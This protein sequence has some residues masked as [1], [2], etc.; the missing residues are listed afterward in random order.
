VVFQWP[1]GTLAG[2]LMPRG[3]QPRSGVMLVLV[4]VSWSALEEKRNRELK[5]VRKLLKAA[6]TQPVCSFL[7]FLN[8]LECQ[9]NGICDVGLAHAEHHPSHPNT[10]ADVLVYWVG[11]SSGGGGFHRGDVIPASSR[12]MSRG[13]LT[14]PLA[15]GKPLFRRRGDAPHP[16][17]W[18]CRSLHVYCGP[19]LRHPAGPIQA[20]NFRSAVAF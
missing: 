14:T 7:V 17:R 5:Q 4:Q 6:C 8:L 16:H 9:A 20:A 13:N 2:S 19:I 15:V 11:F 3:A 12:R 18:V 1:C 10:A